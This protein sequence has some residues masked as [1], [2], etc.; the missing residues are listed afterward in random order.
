MKV[1]IDGTYWMAYTEIDGIYFCEPSTTEFHAERF[2]SSWAIRSRVW[3][4]LTANIE[5][6]LKFNFF[7]FFSYFSHYV[8]T[9]MHTIK[10]EDLLKKLLH[11]E[12]F[13]KNFQKG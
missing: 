12:T 7:H 9:E 13:L 5:L 4:T 3:F 1:W 8:N 10:W 6:Q 2:L 11:V